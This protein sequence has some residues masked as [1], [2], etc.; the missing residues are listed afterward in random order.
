MGL[1]LFSLIGLICSMYIIYN[2]V[3]NRND[4]AVDQKKQ[5][6]IYNSIALEL[7]M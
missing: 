5:R 4:K 6:A 3:P 1:V 7:C 2:Y